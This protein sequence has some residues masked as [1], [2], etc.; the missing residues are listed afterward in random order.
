[1]GTFRS[2]PFL[3][4][5]PVFL[6]RNGSSF[7]IRLG[8][9]KKKKILSYAVSAALTLLAEMCDYTPHDNLLFALIPRSRLGSSRGE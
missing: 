7:P 1:V 2:D 6:L 8:N 9:G 4:K 3:V 5:F